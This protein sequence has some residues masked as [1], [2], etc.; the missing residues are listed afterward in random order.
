MRWMRAGAAAQ[1]RDMNAAIDASKKNSKAAQDAAAKIP[2]Q[3]AEAAKYARYWEQVG[4]HAAIEQGVFGVIADVAA[5]PALIKPGAGSG[6][7]QDGVTPFRQPLYL[8]SIEIPALDAQDRNA[9][10]N[11]FAQH[12]APRIVTV[13]VLVPQQTGDERS[14][15]NNVLARLKALRMTRE[16]YQALNPGLQNVPAELPFL[17]DQG[18][19]GVESPTESSTAMAWT[20]N[21]PYHKTE[22]GR[23]EQ[24]TYPALPLPAK[25]MTFACTL[26]T[27]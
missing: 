21:D 20:F 4:L 24:K 8:D 17:F 5:D 1:R 16:V 7:P 18:P 3:A 22:D 13:K 25:E 14:V 11:P 26:A 10:A 15:R 2:A 19:Q 23:I 9:P 27:P 12:G 6:R